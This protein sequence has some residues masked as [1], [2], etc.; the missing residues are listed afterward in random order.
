MQKL[1][2]D[3]VRKI[4]FACH[5]NAYPVIRDL[6][7]ENP[8]ECAYQDLTLTL[9]AIPAFLKTRTWH[10]DRLDARSTLALVHRD[11]EL[12]NGYLLQL[13]ESLQGTL[14]FTLR[15]GEA[16]LLEA[17]YPVDIL[18]LNE[19]GGSDYMPELL[20]AFV[21]PNDPAIDQ[22]LRAA[23]A[24]LR[25]AGKKDSLEGYQSGDNRRVWE[26]ASAIYTA[27]ANLD[28][29]YAAPPASFEANGQKIRRPAQILSGGL[30]TCLDTSLLFA[31]ALEQ[32]GLHP[33][34]VLTQGHAFAGVWLQPEDFS[35]VLVEDAEILRKCGQFQELVLF[36]TTLTTQHPTPSF[37]Q[38]IALAEE[39]IAPSQDHE[40][41]VALDVKRARMQHIF[42][43][44][45]S[46]EP[47]RINSK[48]QETN[49][50]GFAEAPQ[51]QTATPLSLA[52]ETPAGR[53]ERWQRK[54]LDLT[55]RNPLLNHR[56]SSSSLQV[57]CPDPCLLED[58]LAAGARIAILSKQKKTIQKPDAAL[59]KERTGADLDKEYALGV[60][61]KD[62]ILVDLP[63]AE[64]AKR[65]VEI[66][67][68]AQNALQ[69]GGS[70]T[71]FLALGY[72]LWRKDAKDTVKLRAPLI[73]LPVSMERKSV[74]S[75][76]KLVI[77]EDEPRFNTTLLEM[78]R[79]DFGISIPG[80][81]G[82]LPTDDSGID[83]QG[84]WNLVR[85]AIKD[86]PGFEVVED[87]ALGHFSFA[88]YLMWKDLVDRAEAL[89]ANPVVRH[90]I[91]TPRQPYPSAIAFVE[92]NQIDQDYH[93]T[94]LLTP[95]SADA[96]QMS[97]IATADKGKDF[98]VIGPPGTGKSQTISNLIAHLLGKGKRVLFVSEKTAALEVVYRRLADVGLGP[99]CLELHSSKASKSD[100]LKQLRQSWDQAAPTPDNHWIREAERLK[101]LRDKLNGLVGRLHH[102]HRNGLTA[103]Y[104][105]GVKIRDEDF[106]STCKFHW[107]RADQHDA[108]TLDQMRESAERLGVVAQNL[109]PL[110]DHPLRSIRHGDWSPQWQGLLEQAIATYTLSLR[111]TAEAGQRFLQSLG[112]AHGLPNLKALRQ[113]KILA[114]ALSGCHRLQAAF[115]LDS[116]GATQIEALEAAVHHLHAF[117]QHQATLSCPYNL[118]V[119]KATDLDALADN[120][121]AAA[122]K[123]FLPRFFCQRRIVKR[124]QT[125]GAKGQPRPAQDLP[126]LCALR[127]EGLAIAALEND[128]ANLRDWRGVQTDPDKA[129]HLAAA[130][131]SL[132]AALSQ[133]DVSPAFYLEVK[134]KIRSILQDGNELLSPTGSIGEVARL[135][136]ETYNA[137]LAQR[138]NYHKLSGYELIPSEN[139]VNLSLEEQYNSLSAIMAHR[140]DLKAW[141]AWQK[142][143]QE[144][145]ELELQPLVMALEQSLIAPA[146]ARLAFEASYCAWWSGAVL[147]EDEVLRT[148]T[149]G[150]HEADIR[151]FRAVDQQFR[152]LTANYIAAQLCAHRPH[153]DDIARNSQWGI[154]RREL[155]K[156]IRHKPVRQLVQEAPDALAAL[157]PCFMMS[158][159]SI[160]Q[161]LPTDAQPF[162]VVIFD[163]AS[164]ITVWDAIGAIARGKQIVIAGD[165]RQMPPT[166]F[167]ARNEEDPD[168]EVDQE[169]DLESILDEMLG[170][171]IP[172]RVLNLHYRSR[173]ESLIAFSNQKYYENQLVTFPAPLTP[174]DHGVSLVHPAGHYAR[175]KARHNEGEAKAVVAEVLRRLTHSDAR[176]CQQSIGIVTFNTQQQ[177][178]IEDLLDAE[179]AANPDIEWAFSRDNVLE[180]VFVKNLES[181][182][183]DERDVI[184]FSTTF[185]PDQDGHITMNFGP[186]NRSGGERRLNVA[187]TR[188]RAAMVVFSTLRPEQIDT[189]RTQATAVLHLKH[190]LEYAERGMG[191]LGLQTKESTA[192]SV[193]PFE[194]AVAQAL[195]RLGWQVIAQIGVSSYRVDLGVV[196]PDHP[197][198]FLAGIECDGAMYRSSAYA[199]ERDQVR[200]S[201]LAGLG[202]TLFRAWSADWWVHP[203]KASRQLHELLTRLLQEKRKANDPS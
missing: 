99:F 150:E 9:T 197:G 193:A 202:W 198:E 56:A 74:R 54:L 181:V 116:S 48:V 132:Q 13:S 19:W 143:R 187:L 87:T 65:A 103:H 156:K 179:R 125:L 96:S 154:L 134:S 105:M 127:D 2:F 21:T 177:T 69:E 129:S 44:G 50:Q 196:H 37:S 109:G 67:R 176:I 183:G 175:G 82:A 189:A 39:R 165:P 62:Q 15:Q 157:A 78:L 201:V 140:H 81:D 68:K 12:D 30:A 108:T 128:I 107:P 27:I 90:L 142:R 8:G 75:G 123:W 6:R 113:W 120:W 46:T 80:L 89:R 102:R 149:C 112:L 178:L 158:P 28:L 172:K 163:E 38:A 85:K 7:I 86:M 194:T 110:S 51:W 3:Y 173:K 166:N 10:V 34:V 70:N 1:H 180:P 72:L 94:D 22:I 171:S 73:L 126:A 182:Q 61:E 147:S 97:V 26:I 184:L 121:Q 84:I 45:L 167:F 160:A 122:G 100:V 11:L 130:G 98:I 24:V 106:L 136:A 135:L 92:G 23:S 199:R 153:S 17:T 104:A 159:L 33:L 88:K 133:L 77:N 145:L 170:A 64:L 57:L 168:G 83:V 14:Q 63:E 36:E 139:D 174:P 60:L 191:A 95:L 31:S 91:D 76:V 79:K 161:Y 29:R 195:T 200:Q 16:Q 188:A 117:A 119:W 47:P 41:I 186:L 40:F 203:A 138:E 18:S 49:P 53:L 42:P 152:Q 93:P 71:L 59:Y 141:C 162:D 5:Q 4:N 55:L 43:V 111:T 169:G 101:S 155:E 118:D 137:C 20:A 115:A 114:E 25:T 131:K 144:A 190:F 192:H 185:G 148:F 66:Y 52:E 164:Q 58:K 146:Q 124:L 151:Q 35:T 32:A